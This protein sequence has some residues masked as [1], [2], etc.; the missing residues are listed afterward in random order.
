MP[1]EDIAAIRGLLQEALRPVNERLDGLKKTTD[2]IIEKW[3][4]LN[5]RFI[6]LE[7]QLEHHGELVRAHDRSLREVT[8]QLN[9]LTPKVEELAILVPQACARIEAAFREIDDDAKRR[10]KLEKT[11]EQLEEEFRELEQAT[12]HGL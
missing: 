6:A 10:A 3:V 9:A 1:P 4:D 7:P 5:Q 11:V 12:G 2:D 8:P